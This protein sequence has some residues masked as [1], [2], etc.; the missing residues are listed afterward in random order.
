L[1][2]TLRGNATVALINDKLASFLSAK[3][4]LR[5]AADV[6]SLPD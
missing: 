6:Q 1:A 5:D 3:D 2:F 4:R